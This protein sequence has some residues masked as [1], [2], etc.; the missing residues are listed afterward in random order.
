[1]FAV[2]GC[3]YTQHDHSLVF[4]ALAMCTFACG[5]ARALVL[6]ARAYDGRAQMLWLLSS[7]SVA[8]AGIWATH[9]VAMLAY[10]TSLPMRFDAGLTILSALLAITIPAI[11]AIISLTRLGGVAAGMVFGVGVLAMHYVGIAAL[12]M[13]A[14]YVWNSQMVTSSIIIGISLGGIA[15]HISKLAA[16]WATN[17]LSTGVRIATIVGVHFTAMTALTIIPIGSTTSFGRVSIS[18]EIMSLL[19]TAAG[20]FIVGQALILSVVD[21]HLKGKSERDAARMRIY[22][23]QLEESKTNL[24]KASA[25]AE[26]A[27]NSKSAFL[28]SM[29]HELRTPLNAILGFT[30]TMLQE[31]LGPIG[32]PKYKEYLANVHDSGQHLLELINDILDIARYDAGHVDLEETVFD[33]AAKI[34]DV[35]RMMSGQAHKARVAL[36]TNIPPELPLVKADRRRIRQILLNLI[37]N[38]L[39]FTEAGGT[40]IVKAWVDDGFKMQVSDT[41]IGIA[42]KDFSKALEPFGQVDSSLARKY[43]GT[44]LGLPLTRQLA[45]LHGGTLTLDSEVGVGTK[46]TV[47]L[48]QWRIVSS[49]AD[50][51]A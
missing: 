9:F 23:T 26:S 41:G 11:G 34:R 43:E 49:Q 28:A 12:E 27:N 32:T 13:P 21:R 44:G 29:S 8:G 48:P 38:S 17:I 20:A 25:A 33:P 51:A 1:M 14:R 46:V 35:V 15:G 47:T 31:I 39:K 19:V 45:E 42:P 16:T 2:L 7:G 37:S 5:T 40:V 18:P 24:E 4:A 50:H 36:L 6:R 10:Q 22:I 30:D 3:I